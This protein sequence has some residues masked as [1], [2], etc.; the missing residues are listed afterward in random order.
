MGRVLVDSRE[1]TGALKGVG[2][3]CLNRHVLSC[4]AVHCTFCSELNYLPAVL[5]L[6]N[7]GSAA[8]TM[9]SKWIAFF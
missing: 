2:C 7:Y 5:H 6:L 9:R 8:K 4:T 1:L 3:K